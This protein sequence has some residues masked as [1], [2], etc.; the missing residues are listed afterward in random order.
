MS[1]QT[2][3]PR[4]AYTVLQPGIAHKNPK[5]TVP[6]CTRFHI[7]T[8]PMPLSRQPPTKSDKLRPLAK[9]GPKGPQNDVTKPD[10]GQ[11]Q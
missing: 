2:C 9:R 6:A 8:T 1:S 4:N 5:S 11:T 3:P 10:R 7:C